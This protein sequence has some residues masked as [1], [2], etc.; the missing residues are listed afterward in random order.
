MEGQ[1]RAEV[2]SLEASLCEPEVQSA[3]EGQDAGFVVVSKKAT[4]RKEKEQRRQARD[5][6]KRYALMCSAALIC[7]GEEYVHATAAELGERFAWLRRCPKWSR[8]RWCWDHGEELGS[9][10]SELYELMGEV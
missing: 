7:D 5:E 9:I 4:R 10:L 2:Q 1:K 3:M 6:Q 8:G